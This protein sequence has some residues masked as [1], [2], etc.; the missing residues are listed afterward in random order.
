MR[1]PNCFLK[2]FVKTPNE[3]KAVCL[4]YSLINPF[5]ATDDNGNY[6]IRVKQETLAKRMRVS[7]Q[8]IRRIIS[9]LSSYGFI[10]SSSRTVKSN[11]ELGTNV[12]TIKKYNLHKDYFVLTKRALNMVYG[13]SFVVYALCCK[14]AEEN[15]FYKSYSE[16]AELTGYKR[17]EVMHI[18]GLLVSDGLLAK[19]SKRTKA[20]DYTDNTYLV[21]HCSYLQYALNKAKKVSEQKKSL[22]PLVRNKA[23]QIPYNCNYLN[24]DYK[25]F[26]DKCQAFFKKILLKVGFLR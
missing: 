25:S 10:I 21:L 5:T 6:V 2:D 24:N 13:K 12:Y 19:Y 16:L 9:S 8:T 14:L 7:I 22:V 20:G 3:F 18:I 23:Q 1:I 17:S 11:G 4:L 15:K 26:F